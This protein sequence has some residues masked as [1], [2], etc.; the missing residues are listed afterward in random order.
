MAFPDE[1]AQERHARY[2]WQMLPPMPDVSPVLAGVLPGK[3]AGSAS[4]KDV[5]VV[6]LAM[7][8]FSEESMVCPPTVDRVLK[9]ADEILTDGFVTD[10]EP[11]MANASSLCSNDIPPMW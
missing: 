8:S 4:P 5:M 6:H 2:L 10:T 9:L 3:P 7:L 1:R 11:L